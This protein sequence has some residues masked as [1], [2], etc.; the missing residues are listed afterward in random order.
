MEDTIKDYKSGNYLSLYQLISEDVEM[1]IARENPVEYSEK[2]IE[3]NLKII[4]KIYEA[5]QEN[6][7]MEDL[8]KDEKDFELFQ[9]FLQDEKVEVLGKN[10]K[11]ECYENIR[12][13]A[14]EINEK[15]Q[16]CIDLENKNAIHYENIRK[17][18]QLLAKHNFAME[19]KDYEKDTTEEERKSDLEDVDRLNSELILLKKEVAEIFNQRL[20]ELKFITDWRKDIETY[21][22]SEFARN[23][24]IPKETRRKAKSCG[25]RRKRNATVCANR[26]HFGGF[27]KI[28]MFRKY[29]GGSYVAYEY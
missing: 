4:T 24:C 21:L 14:N 23:K 20:E 13:N 27:G 17:L 11:K 22:K 3:K 29:C 10:K 9:T 2:M 18:E 7:A 5:F 16:A 25:R 15:I 19:Q 8:K 6:Q 12:K 28:R 1:F 26:R